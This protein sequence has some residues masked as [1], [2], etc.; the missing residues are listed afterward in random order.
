M[1][2][3]LNNHLI[4]NDILF[5]NQFGFTRQKSTTS[6]IIKLNDHVLK[7][8]DNTNYT[9]AIFLD[10]QKAFDTVN[11]TI[12]LK[13][14]ENYGVRDVALQWFSSYLSNRKQFTSFYNE[15]SKKAT[16]TYSVPQGSILGPL[17][18]NLY[19]NDLKN[20]LNNSKLILFADD[21]CLY[22]SGGN[23]ADLIEIA[24]AE[25]ENINYWVKANRL[26]LN[27][28]KSHYMIFK[29]RKKLQENLPQVTINNSNLTLVD[30]TKFLGLKLQSNLKWD[31]H[32]YEISR[33][34]NKYSSL[35]YLTRH[36]LNSQSLI[37]IYQSLVYPL[38]VYC[39]VIWG[40]SPQKHLNPLI[41]SQKRVI[42]TIKNRN[43]Y[44]HTNNDFHTLGFLKIK[45]INTY[46]ASIFVYKSL[47]R[48]SYPFEYFRYN[49]NND[50]N[51][52]NINNL[53]AP[54]VNSDQS[55]RSPSYYCCDIWNNLPLTIKEKPSVA[56]FKFALKHH[57]IRMYLQ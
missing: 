24:N 30:N 13:K 55:Q 57:L 54:L 38:L 53:L 28:T 32:I 6:A 43:R 16:S 33:K 26:T 4:E 5:E 27:I 49:D 37:S 39:N 25:L 14:L 7:E 15:H 20:S 34:I 9:L 18:F 40:N 45:E 36:L 44:Y 19:I 29:R 56:S 50:Y 52:R 47:N 22:S 8:F 35:I 21:S 12:L 51:L 23:I 3:R 46:F 1:Y 31:Q 48:I 10:F 2:N 17:L 42:R 41:V 11:H